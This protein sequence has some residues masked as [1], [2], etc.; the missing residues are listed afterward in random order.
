MDSVH[1]LRQTHLPQFKNGLD[2]DLLLSHALHRPK[3]FLYSHDDY[4]PTKPELNRFQKYSRLY[5]TGYSIA[6]IIQH[7]EFYGLDF[8]VNKHV[9]VPRPETELL[10][11]HAIKAA[12]IAPSPARLAV[13]THGETQARGEVRRGG[14]NHPIILI[15]V[16]TGSGSI[17]ISILKKTSQKINKTFAIDISSRALTVAKKNARTHSVL[18]TFLHGNLLKPL[19]KNNLTIQQFNNLTLLITANLPYLTA[20]Q[21]KSEP[22]VQKEPRIALVA[23]NS[24]LELYEKLLKQIKRLLFSIDC[25]LLTCLL[26]I[27]PSQTKPIQ[28]L[29][30]TILPK[31]QVKIL[32]DLAGLDRV[33]MIEIKQRLSS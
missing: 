25:C 15:D 6:A 26:E 20:A 24:G 9:L 14:S 28:Q 22:S 13:A 2:F 17:P 4:S 33:V 21:F 10:V 3:E 8:F 19:L 11:E 23:K 7:K 5:H 12:N 16:G 31:G 27:D 29:I 1:S 30:K 18:I 32:K